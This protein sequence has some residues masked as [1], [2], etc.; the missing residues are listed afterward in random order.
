MGTRMN[1]ANRR[2]HRRQSEATLME[3][4]KESSPERA[5]R[6]SEL[7][8]ACT[9]EFRIQPATDPQPTTKQLP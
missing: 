9:S 3:R 5:F 4:M 6:I 1:E 7:A 2:T 8:A